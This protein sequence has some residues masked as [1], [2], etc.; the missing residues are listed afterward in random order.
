MKVCIIGAGY[1]GLPLAV[2][3]ADAGLSVV[4]VETQ[5]SRRERPL[6]RGECS[7]EPDLAPLV[8]SGLAAGRLS[9]AS[10]CAETPE[11]IDAWFVCVGTPPDTSGRPDLSAVYAAVDAIAP[12][13]RHNSIAII[14]ST[15]PPGTTDALRA[16]LQASLRS[17]R[18]GFP[19]RVAF[20]PEFLRQGSAVSDTRAPERI[21]VGA[22]D[23]A[24]AHDVARILEP[25][26]RHGARLLTLPTRSAEMS[27]YA[28]NAMLAMRISFMNEI[29][30]LCE[31]VGADI[32][33]V[34]GVI[35]TDHRIGPHGLAAG[36]GYGGSCLPKDL[37]ALIAFA[38]D[39]GVE[40]FL[41]GATRKR[42]AMQRV[43]FATRILRGLGKAPADTHVALWGLSF[44]P[45][46]DDVRQAPSLDVIES[47]LNAG[48][49]L[50]LHDPSAQ[51]RDAV[52]QR[53]ANDARGERMAFFDDPYSAARDA[54]AIAIVTEWPCYRAAELPRL[55]TLM[56]GNL[57][58]D[59]RNALDP[60]MVEAAG[61][62]YIGIGR[63]GS[64]RPRPIE[65]LL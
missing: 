34:R 44:K 35:G 9:F 49:S 62:C 32:E 24:I 51:A 30:S 48:C 50:K 14:K 10:A 42:N 19:A 58:A 16:R 60:R 5:A 55:A 59:G 7:N 41:L 21:V 15:V 8:A 22:D 28:A 11:D 27:K 4:C 64:S 20:C 31:G 18:D 36:L 43:G 17:R 29:V 23:P 53:F 39:V 13:L 12:R 56:R 38:D 6:E 33:L 37:D 25:F 63:G 52:R 3:L 57:I 61:L 45:F 47:L 2:C 1:V 26:L 40:P 54:D 46:T 65:E